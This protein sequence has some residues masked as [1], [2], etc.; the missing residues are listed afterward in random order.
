MNPS[1]LGL[2][3]VFGIARRR[4]RIAWLVATGEN[5]VPV[6]GAVAV[7]L[8]L[9]GWLAPWRWPEPAAFG[10]S[11]GVALALVG[12]A[13]AFRVSD[14]KVA[15]ALDRGLE[16]ND[17]VTSALEIDRGSPFAPQLYSQVESLTTDDAARAV[18]V[19]FNYKPWLLG[20]VLLAAAV[21]LAVVRNPADDD[22]DRLAEERLAIE[23][24]AEAVETR[25]EELAQDPLT[26]DLAEELGALAESLSRETDL[27]A[28]LK[29]LEEASTEL[30]SNTDAESLA[31][32]EIGRAHV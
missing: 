16:A 3:R 2:S 21:A 24:V 27:D 9:I 23:Q 22:R 6:V 18:R 30:E 25:A 15:R 19:P 29:K 31:Q 28:A 17:I 26:A 14:F 12:Y 4:L 13:L 7:A 1:D 10:L 11:A 20:A 32:R 8:V 5:A